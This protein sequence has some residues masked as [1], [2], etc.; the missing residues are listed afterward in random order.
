MDL[1]AYINW[2][3]SPEIFKLGPFSIRW[4]G[5]LFALGFIVGYQI[6]FYIFKL[7]KKKQ[8]DLEA[9]TITM[10]LG[11]VI[12]ARLGHC[13]FYEPEYYLSHPIEILTVWHGGLASHG[14]AI[15][16]ALALWYYVRKRPDISMVWI[17]DRI[18]IVTAL[19]GCF[20]RLG[21]FFNSEILGSPA[22]NPW[23][24]VFTRIDQIPRHPAQL[25][26]SISYL[27]IFI[28]LFL[29]YRGK[30]GKTAPGLLFGLFFLLVF[31]M[32]FIIEF[33]K[34]V[35]VDFERTMTLNMGQL[36]SIPLILIGIAF[37]IYSFKKKQITHK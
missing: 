25:Y 5:L 31:G 28:I 23:S 20:I 11:T 22:D 2:S 13:L 29:I 1:L 26:E 6:M 16:I 14:A 18:G 8:K 19:A 34:D 15:G 36:L 35:Q 3:V 30:K 7:E 4:Y 9:L 10:I 32:R 37:I 27:A 17:L 21:N 24:V 33:F 12:G